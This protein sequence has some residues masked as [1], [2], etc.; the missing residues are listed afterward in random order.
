M[1]RFNCN[2]KCRYSSIRQFERSRELVISNLIPS[3]SSLTAA[4]TTAIMCIR[5]TVPT[6]S[7]LQFLLHLIGQS[8]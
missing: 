8:Y 3:N 7:N 4:F 5:D 6:N 1:S 2:Y